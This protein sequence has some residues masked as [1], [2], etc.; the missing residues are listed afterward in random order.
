M[1]QYC[2]TAVTYIP[3]FTMPFTVHSYF[4]IHELYQVVFVN[5]PPPPPPPSQITEIVLINN[6]AGLK[7]FFISIC[8][9]ETEFIHNLKLNLYVLKVSRHFV[10]LFGWVCLFFGGRGGFYFIFVGRLFSLVWGDGY[11]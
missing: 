6:I 11:V 5:P 1:G 4:V 10:C 2:S 7:T 9:L 3:Q 8:Y